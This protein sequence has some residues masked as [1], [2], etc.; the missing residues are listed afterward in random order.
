MRSFP[1]IVLAL[2]LLNVVYARSNDKELDRLK[3]LDA[4]CEQVRAE[5]LKPLQE[6]KIEQCVKVDKR[7]REWCENYFK[8]YGWGSASGTGKRTERFF[9]QI[10]E[11][12]E[13]DRKSVV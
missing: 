6:K 12:V 13:A 11:C 7:E 9:D 4:K 8:D 5:K 10:P 1:I 2:T 3:A